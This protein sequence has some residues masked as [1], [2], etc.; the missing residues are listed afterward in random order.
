MRCKLSV[1]YVLLKDKAPVKQYQ[2]IGRIMAIFF[3]NNC[4][5]IKPIR[6]SN[7]LTLYVTI[8]IMMKIHLHLIWNPLDGLNLVTLCKNCAMLLTDKDTY[9]VIKGG[10]VQLMP[11]H[12]ATGCSIMPTWEH[13]TAHSSDTAI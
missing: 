7:S 2:M 10:D 13:V 5:V 12:H 3:D 4:Y 8:Y 1:N 9:K 6:L 11:G